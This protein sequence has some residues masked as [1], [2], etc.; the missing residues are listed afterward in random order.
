MSCL[1]KRIAMAAV[2]LVLACA[3]AAVALA[4]G[5]APARAFDSWAHDGA[6]SC[7]ACHRGG[8]VTD[9]V[10]TT[11]HNGFLSYPERTCW[12]CHYPGQDTAPLSS[13]GSACTQQCHLYRPIDKAYVTPYSHTDNPHLGSQGTPNGC[14]DCHQTSV[15][16]FNPGES[17]HHSGEATG[18]SDCGACHSGYQRHAGS[19]AC[20]KCHPQAEAFHLYT[21]S[22]PGFKSCGSCHSMKHAGKKVPTGKCATCHKGGGSGPATKAQHAKSVTKKYVC[23]ACHSQRAHASAVNKSITCR[24]CHRGKYHAAQK[25]PPS[26]ICLGCHPSARYHAVGY[27]CVVCHRSKVH[28]PTPGR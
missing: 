14:L 15:N 5:A 26:S 22:S 27:A 7:D 12:S 11:C 18:F 10:C 1:Q 28:D 25:R 4:L 20:T 17:P 19:V 23:S 21:A 2:L 3:D 24:T 8:P 16:V 13:P 9:A 6:A